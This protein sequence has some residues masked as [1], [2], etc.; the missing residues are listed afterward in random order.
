MLTI[1]A[2]PVEWIPSNECKAAVPCGADSAPDPVS[3]TENIRLEE[4]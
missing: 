1:V 3:E 4:A 2:A